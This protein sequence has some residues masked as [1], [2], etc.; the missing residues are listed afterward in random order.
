MKTRKPC[1]GFDSTICRYCR[2]LD[3]SAPRL[4][5]K[6]AT[7]PVTGFGQCEYYLN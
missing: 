5:E 2:R 7:D 4:V 1:S 6:L 3:K